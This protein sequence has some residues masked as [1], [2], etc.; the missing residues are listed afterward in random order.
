[1]TPVK[2]PDEHHHQHLS[3]A[4][5]APQFRAAG[6]ATSAFHP[7][8]EVTISTSSSGTTRSIRRRLGS[9]RETKLIKAFGLGGENWMRHA[10]PVSVW[11]RFAVLPLLAVS[12]WSRDWIGWWSLVPVAL[13]LVFMMVNP[14]LFPRPR[15]TRNW[16]SRAVFGERIWADRNKAEIPEQFRQSRVPNVTYAFQL[17]GLAVLAYGLVELRLLDGSPAWLIV[18]CAKAWS[19]T[20]SCCCSR[21]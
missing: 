7:P 15:S 14:R 11:T 20:A 16:A 1:M 18:Q 21:T 10:N 5:R 19:A 12:V 9:N 4:G 3:A 8:G 2:G 13:S 6:E 17:F